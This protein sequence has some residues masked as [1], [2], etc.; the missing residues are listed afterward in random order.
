M[1]LYTAIVI[2]LC[3]FGMG[4]WIANI[5]KLVTGDWTTCVWVISGEEILRVCGIFLPPLG[6]YLGIKC[7]LE[8]GQ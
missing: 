6:A 2:V 4:G 8:I 5:I 3:V 7:F 1:K